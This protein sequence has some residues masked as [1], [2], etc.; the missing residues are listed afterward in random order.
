MQVASVGIGTLFSNS[1]FQV[2]NFLYNEIIL[3]KKWD[4]LYKYIQIFI[5]SLSL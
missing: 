5:F 1:I 4:L 2:N 3:I